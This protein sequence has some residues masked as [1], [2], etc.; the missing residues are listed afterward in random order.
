MQGIAHF[1][2]KKLMEVLK[3]NYFRGIIFCRLHSGEKSHI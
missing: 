1:L 2:K 3:A